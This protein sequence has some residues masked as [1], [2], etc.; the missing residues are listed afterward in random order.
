MISQTYGDKRILEVHAICNDVV[1]KALRD[2]VDEISFTFH[3]C[4]A[5]FQETAKALMQGTLPATIFRSFDGVSYKESIVAQLKDMKA[6]G[7][8]DFVLIQ[9]DQ[10][11]YLHVPIAT[12]KA[13]VD[14][15]RSNPD[16]KF[17]HV[18][19]KEGYPTAARKPLETRAGG[20]IRFHRYDSRDFQRDGPNVY[21]YNDGTYL[22]SIDFVLDLLGPE[23]PSDVWGMEMA[24]KSVFDRNP[25]DRWGAEAV[26]FAAANLHGR[27]INRAPFD[28]NMGRFFFQEVLD[29]IR[30]YL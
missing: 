3:N 28:Q 14:F 24:L 8:T 23:I 27:N 21:A 12:V 26:L 22:A 19:G 6:R 7:F 2:S 9:D 11:G 5:Q 17:L 1:G 4:P 18:F 30:K 29:K 20:G 16:V 13:V 10:Y 15:Y 25:I